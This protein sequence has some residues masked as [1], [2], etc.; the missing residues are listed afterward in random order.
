MQ[1]KRVDDYWNVDSNRFLA[2]SWKGFTKFTL[3][4]ERP[5]RGD[6]CGPGW[7]LTK[8]QTTTTPDHVWPE[9]WT[10][11]GKAARNRERTRLEKQGAKT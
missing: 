8:I 5:P 6:K 9:V 3:L 4:K 11:M 2:D 10:K 7:I 1:E